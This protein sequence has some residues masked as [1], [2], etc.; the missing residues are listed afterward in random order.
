MHESHEWSCL[1]IWN[2][3]N[4]WFEEAGAA[5]SRSAMRGRFSDDRAKTDALKSLSPHEERAGK[6]GGERGCLF[7]RHK[8]F[9]LAD[10]I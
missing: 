6:R 2:L 9:S 8:R 1:L 3:E 4:E 7:L 10:K 5:Q